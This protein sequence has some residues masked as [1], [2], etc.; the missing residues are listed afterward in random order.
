MD[1]THAAAGGVG[2]SFGAALAG[3]IAGTWKLDPQTAADWVVVATGVASFVGAMVVWYIRW[4]YPSAPP[5]PQ[6]PAA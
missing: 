4:K 5:P 1:S 3:A 2:L 6:I